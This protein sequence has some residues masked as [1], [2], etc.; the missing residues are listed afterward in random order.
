MNDRAVMEA[1]ENAE[2]NGITNC[3]FVSASAEAIF[4]D[5]KAIGRSNKDVKPTFIRGFPRDTTTVVLDPPRK[6]CSEI[7]LQQL[8]VTLHSR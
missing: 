2:L 3:F 5:F 7:F 6:G 8:Y 1:A 4:G